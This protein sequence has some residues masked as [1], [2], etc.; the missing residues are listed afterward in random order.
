M[1]VVVVVL[2]SIHTECSN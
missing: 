2:G 1:V